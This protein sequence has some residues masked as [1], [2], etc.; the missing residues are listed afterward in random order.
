MNKS[1]TFFIVIFVSIFCGAFFLYYFLDQRSDL[2]GKKTVEDVIAEHRPQLDARLQNDFE[3]TGVTFPPEELAFLVIKED[4]KLE[5]WAR[6]DGDW[7]II[8]AVAITAASGKSGPKLREGDRQIPEGVYEVVG[9]NPN[10]SYHLSMKLNYP[11]EFDRYWANKEG[12]TN[13]G[14]D[15]FIHGKAVSIGCIA[16]GDDAI[17]ELF[18]IV[19]KVGIEKVKV[20]ISPRDPRKHALA[21]NSDSPE[22]TEELYKN[23]ESEFLSI[24]GT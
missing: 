23:I 9:L 24:S 18:Y 10:S 15:I 4:K 19:H 11:N 3:N 2:M 17:E 8:K 1:M 12:R 5:L 22:W 13:P 20:V 14:S 6:N 7:K 16:V 21:G